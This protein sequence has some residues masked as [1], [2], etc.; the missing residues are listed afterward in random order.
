MPDMSYAVLTLTRQMARRHMARSGE[1]H[2]KAAKQIFW[3]LKGTMG[4]GLCYTKG[5]AK[6]LQCYVDHEL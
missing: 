2:L 5:G 1:V 3:Y 4:L 6:N